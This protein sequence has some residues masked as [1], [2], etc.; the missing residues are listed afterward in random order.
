MVRTADPTE[1]WDSRGPICI[2]DP[3]T[4]D[5]REASRYDNPFAWTGQRYDAGVRLYHFPL[6]TYSPRAGDN[7]VGG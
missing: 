6:R 4:G 1:S 3:L 7:P 5:R 2:E